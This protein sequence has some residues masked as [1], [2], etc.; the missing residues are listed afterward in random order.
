MKRPVFF[1]ALLLVLSLPL[2]AA[3]QQK[4][5]SPD[6]PSEMQ[7]V[8]TMDQM[9]SL[10]P[11]LLELGW[12]DFFLNA[13][14]LNGLRESGLSS[15]QVRKLISLQHEFLDLREQEARK[16]T[17][18]N[19]AFVLELNRDAVSARQVEIRAR[20]LFGLE[21]T[22]VGL[23]LRYLLRAINV[24]SHEQHRRL[25]RLVDPTFDPLTKPQFPVPPGVPRVW[26][27]LGK[28]QLAQ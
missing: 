4:E 9:R 19:L 20:E 5:P 28:M 22:L 13:R 10:V 25:V 26:R 2:L 8:V 12:E 14:L 3:G 17:G 21:A 23:R 16:A 6:E 27:P 18:A 15:D 24:L 7:D 11:R 1:L